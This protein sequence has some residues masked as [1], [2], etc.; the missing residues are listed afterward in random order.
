MSGDLALGPGA[1]FD[2][3]RA[4]VARWGARATGIGDDAAILHVPRG[5]VIVA[6]VDSF[7]EHRHF[8]RDWLTPREVGYRSA[9]AALSDLAAMA[10]SPIALLIAINTPDS[11]LA[12]LPEIADGIG[13]AAGAV[14]AHIAGGNLASASELSITTTVLGASFRPLRRNGAVDGDVVYVT[15]T[16][17]GPAAA[18][19][20]LRAGESPEDHWDRFA[21]PVPR[22]AEA[23]W[24]A[25]R[26]VMSAIDISDGLIGDVRHLAAASGV[27]VEIDTARV[28]R[29]ADV[30]IEL[31]LES[32]E[33]Y[34][35]VVTSPQPLDERE[36]RERFGIPLTMI[37]R[38][39][40]AGAGEVLLDGVRVVGAVSHDHF[41]R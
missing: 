27:C 31:A 30:S 23:L 18:L 34:E 21:H 39:S 36:F 14:G 38:V 29:A 8:Q 24:L 19:S 10:A 15:G 40:S 7:V 37:G 41:A 26:G 20:R 1:E 25:D 22:I 28:P 4:M 13:E 2:A 5:D 35:L 33:E 9:A 16:L 32:G 3:I 17:G 12:N 6:S 11:W